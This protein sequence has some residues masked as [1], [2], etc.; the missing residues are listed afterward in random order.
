[1]K[2][3]SATLGLAMLVSLGAIM[4]AAAA[5][6]A[7][8]PAATASATTPAKP[9]HYYVSLKAK[10]PG[11]DVVNVKPDTKMLVGKHYYKT[12]SDAEKAM[13]GAKACKA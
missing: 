6:T 7:A 10:G 3:N 1:M 4:P 8:K 13:A 9:T 2:I 5:T 11:C 12:E